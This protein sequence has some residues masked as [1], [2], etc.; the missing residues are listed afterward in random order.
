MSTQKSSSFQDNPTVSGDTWNSS[1]SF[2]AHVYVENEDLNSASFEGCYEINTV[3]EHNTML[4]LK[5]EQSS[6][7]WLGKVQN[8]KAIPSVK[9]DVFLVCPPG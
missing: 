2:K 9:A 7:T 8:S 5:Y 1:Q 4:L 3:F 6:T